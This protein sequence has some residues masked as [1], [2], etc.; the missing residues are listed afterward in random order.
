MVPAALATR[1]RNRE[2]TFQWLEGPVRLVVGAKLQ[3]V[4]GRQIEV[5]QR[6]AFFMGLERIK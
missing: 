5:E 4:G 2:E 6:A 1:R 3:I